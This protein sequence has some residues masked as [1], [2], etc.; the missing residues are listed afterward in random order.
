[1]QT[2]FDKY[3][4]KAAE[5]KQIAIDRVNAYWK[6]KYYSLKRKLNKKA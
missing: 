4:L 3:K 1:L 6:K 5:E 2:D